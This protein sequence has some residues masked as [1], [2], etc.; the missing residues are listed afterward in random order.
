MEQQYH[1]NNFEQDV[2]PHLDA[3]YN[4]ARWLVRDSTT[5][6]DVVRHA[7]VRASKYFASFRG[8]RDRTWL[9]QIVRNAAYSCIKSR[10]QNTE[11]SLGA[12]TRVADEGS[13]GIDLP[14]PRPGHGARPARRDD[15]RALDEALNALPVALRECLILREIEMLSC[16]QIARIT[17]VPIGTVMSRLSRARH[18]LLDQA[19]GNESESL[20]PNC[21]PQIAPADSAFAGLR[22]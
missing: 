5:A 16:R 22:E 20:V 19:S 11:V 13:M 21:S 6:E 14:D 4:L 17:D 10:R 2:L 15:L 7:I 3:A 18:A 1:L 12:G 9:L 8:E